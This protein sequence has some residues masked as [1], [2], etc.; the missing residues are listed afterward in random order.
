MKLLIA[1][2]LVATIAECGQSKPASGT[3]R[4]ATAA[5]PGTGSVPASE[6]DLTTVF[7]LTWSAP[8]NPDE[9]S[10]FNFYVAAADTAADFQLVH[11]ETAAAGAENAA[12]D[13][14]KPAY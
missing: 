1:A 8:T 3:T 9:V 5:S 4:T 2:A 10:R 7:A 6:A 12:I 13:T 11:S 14:L